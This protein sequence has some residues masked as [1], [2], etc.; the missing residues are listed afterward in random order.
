MPSK[1][2]KKKPSKKITCNDTVDR[3][4]KVVT[5]PLVL[6]AAMHLIHGLRSDGK[7]R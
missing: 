5:D 2:K 7:R 3:V 1:K 4:I 6:N